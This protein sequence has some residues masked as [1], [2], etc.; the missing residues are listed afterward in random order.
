MRARLLFSALILAPLRCKTD[1][2]RVQWFLGA[3]GGRCER[4][5]SVAGG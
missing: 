3:V 4:L 5:Q 1:Q 2:R